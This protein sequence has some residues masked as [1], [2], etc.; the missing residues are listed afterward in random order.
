MTV[1]LA[2][3]K[4][5]G[6]YQGSKV[7]SGMIAVL[8]KSA[9]DLCHSVEF[10]KSVKGALLNSNDLKCLIAMIELARREKEHLGYSIHD[11]SY[12]DLAKSIEL[13]NRNY[14][15]IKKAVFRL[16]SVKVATVD[17]LSKTK[18][19][20][21]FL[22]D[23]S[24]L[25][26]KPF[27][28]E[29]LTSDSNSFKVKG[30]GAFSY[31]IADWIFDDLHKVYTHIDLNILKQLS[32]SSTIAL[33]KL[34]RPYVQSQRV[35]REVRSRIFNQLEL[36]CLLFM[37]RLVGVYPSE[38]KKQI[39]SKIKTLSKKNLDIEI[40]LVKLGSEGFQFF[41][42]KTESKRDSSELSKYVRKFSLGKK[43]SGNINI[44]NLSLYE[45]CK[46][47]LNINQTDKYIIN[48]DG[49]PGLF[50]EVLG[51]DNIENFV[52]KLVLE[53]GRRGH[54]GYIYKSL[55]NK[56]LRELNKNNKSSA[57]SIEK[58]IT[59]NDIR[60]ESSDIDPF[61]KNILLYSEA[62][63]AS[64]QYL[65]NKLNSP[66]TQ[67]N[68]NCKDAFDGLVKQLKQHSQWSNIFIDKLKKRKFS[69]ALVMIM[70]EVTILWH[71]SPFCYTN[72]DK[73]KFI[74]PWDFLQEFEVNM[75][76][77][78]PDKLD[79]ALYLMDIYQKFVN[80]LQSE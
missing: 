72:E 23:E 36:S 33:Y 30:S 60:K 29:I 77:L 65:V 24:E 16:S 5:L 66:N 3:S 14:E 13:P 41:I 27:T 64:S 53:G 52:K 63:N 8:S 4:E 15:L 31:S 2:Y 43:T 1:R 28:T 68:L 39:E 75:D 48:K 12:A 69:Y 21:T 50:S 10:S 56:Y 9:V 38:A 79:K 44:E 40:K 7:I 78:P 46:I 22:S 59:A 58:K 73:E 11:W 54:G 34:C 61:K 20:I 42:K 49:Y 76:M 70:Y 62:L 55:K 19:I 18:S 17:D 47:Y 51:I 67:Y 74:H 26:Q 35:G 80:K 37:P 32:S 57:G 71:R 45:L 6:Q 25:I